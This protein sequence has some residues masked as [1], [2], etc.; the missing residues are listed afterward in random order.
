MMDTALA[1][2]KTGEKTY[3]GVFQRLG[4]YLIDCLI[5]F[6]CLLA[7]QAALYAVNPIVSIIQSG[8]Q[9]TGMQ[10]HLWVFATATIPFLFYFTLT[11]CRAR[12]ATFGQQM[13]KL[14]VVDVNEKRIG[15]GQALLRSAVMLLPFELNHALMFHL[16]PQDGSPPS[17]HFWIGYIGVWVLIT[18]YLAAIKLTRRR[19]SVHDLVAGTTV[20]RAG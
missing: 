11:L 8:G 16:A 1:D 5:L 6:V 2:E 13:L 18:V 7:L 12:Q 4:A 9:P 19:Q 15:F 3:A 17:M 14:K 10:L 20:E